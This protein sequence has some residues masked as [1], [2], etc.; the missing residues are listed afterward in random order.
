MKIIEGLKDLKLVE[1]KLAKNAQLIEMYASALSNEKLPFDT[2]VEQQKQV[3]SLIQSSKDL[4]AYYFALKTAID[5][6]NLETK[7][8]FDFGTYSI[9]D[10]I[11]LNPR[12]TKLARAG[13]NIGSFLTRPYSSLN[14]SAAD[15]R[16][17]GLNNRGAS[18]DIKVL[19]LFSEEHK[20]NELAKINDFL[21]SISARLEVINA[22]TD[23]IGV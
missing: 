12:N 1:E 3:Q 22:T 6:T 21:G 7:V 19:R 20:N 2:E 11:L 23:I 17:Q 16:M 5:K 14:T 9:H 8:T 15:C 18:N 13:K 4:T 10:L